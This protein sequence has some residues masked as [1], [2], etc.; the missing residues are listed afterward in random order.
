VEHA[1]EQG[2]PAHLQ[3]EDGDAASRR[4]F[5]QL[6]TSSGNAQCQG[7]LATAGAS[8]D[9]PGLPGLE[10]QRVLVQVQVA[11]LEP[12]LVVQ[13]HLQVVRRLDDGVDQPD[14]AL[15]T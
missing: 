6:G 12:D 8:A 3:R 9:D 13:A 11:R 14:F 15:F 7:R 5:E 2:H 1:A 10:P 4:L